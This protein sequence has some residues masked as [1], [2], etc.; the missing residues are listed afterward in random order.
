MPYATHTRP[1]VGWFL[2]WLAFPVATAA[3]ADPAAPG[4]KVSYY[5][6]VRPILQGQCQGCH[7]PAKA[8]G[9]YVM[10]S[11]A[12]LLAG[13]DSK[14]EAV[15]PGKPDESNLLDLITPEAG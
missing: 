13:G 15:V 10:T 11:F 12:K 14:A 4:D 1:K 9:G 3:A 7:Q 5:K 2:L 8:G 6:Q